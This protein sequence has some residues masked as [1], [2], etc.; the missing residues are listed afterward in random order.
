MLP[1]SHR[2]VVITGASTGI[3]RDAALAMAEAGMNVHAGVRREVDAESMLDEATRRGIAHR[4]HPVRIDVTDEASVNAAA[5]SIT[6]TLPQGRLFALVNNAG[7]V[8][9]GPAELL[10]VADVR[11]QFEVNFFGQL[12]VTKA[13]LPALRAWGTAC[14]R[15]SRNAAAVPRFNTA[16]GARIIMMS[17]I[18]GRA[19]LPFAWPY[20]ASK[21]ALEALA[22]GLRIELRPFNVQTILIEPGAIKT[23]IWDKSLLANTDSAKAWPEADRR[24]Y[25]T[26]Y[27]AFGDLAVRAGERAVPVARVS[28]AVL[29]ALGARSPRAR[30]LVG[31]D[32]HMQVIVQSILPTRLMDAAMNAE[33]ERRARQQGGHRP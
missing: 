27:E 7:I 22:D 21:F 30:Y 8:V 28:R 31:P 11:R 32:A 24:L 25:Q 3:G 10:T 19:S 29:R 14:P 1:T 16:T 15:S 13:F 33:I 20:A 2:H 26:R 5:A 9:G 17:S 12:T 18:S 23:P 4:V 6:P